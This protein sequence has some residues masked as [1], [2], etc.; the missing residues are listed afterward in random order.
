MSGRRNATRDSMEIEFSP[1]Q[2]QVSR[3]GTLSKGT[4]AKSGSS[5]ES[6]PLQGVAELQSQLNELAL[7]RPERVDAVRPALSGGQ[8]PPD[9]LLN[10]IAHLLAIRLTQ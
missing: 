5:S 8:Y 7:S 9:E 4:P 3:A 10:G 2:L 1:N 6:A